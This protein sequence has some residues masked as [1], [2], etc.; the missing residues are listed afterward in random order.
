MADLAAL[1][2]AAAVAVMPAP[3]PVANRMLDVIAPQGRRAYTRGA[4]L[5]ELTDEVVAIAMKHA[6]VAPP[7]TNPPAPSS[8]Q[9]FWALG[10][11]ISEDADESS[12]AFSREGAHWFWEVATQCD[13]ASDDEKF[14]TWADRLYTEL[15][16]HFL[17]NCYINLT[18]DLGPEWRKG[19]WGS[20]EKY[21]KLVQA[22]E[23]WDPANMFR[24]NKNIEPET[25]TATA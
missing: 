25:A 4:Y 8:V 19:A 7:R 14:M 6:E 2:E 20:Q 1:G 5:A 10:G 18:T 15:K 17:A 21:R 16:P 12:T 22:K 9:N 11:A 23:K 24:F 3:W 13:D